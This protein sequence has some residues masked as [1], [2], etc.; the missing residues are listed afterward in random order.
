MKIKIRNKNKIEDTRINILG[1]I[2]FVLLFFIWFFYGEKTSESFG[3]FMWFW[4]LIWCWVILGYIIFLILT[5]SVRKLIYKIIKTHQFQ[6]VKSITMMNSYLRNSNFLNHHN[7]YQNT[8]LEKKYK[9]YKYSLFCK[10]IIKNATVIGLCVIL[11]FLF[12]NMLLQII[13]LPIV[14]TIAIVPLILKDKIV[15]L[16]RWEKPKRINKKK[17]ED[18]LYFRRIIPNSFQKSEHKI[19]FY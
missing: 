3:K 2:Y 14:L 15:S 17:K 8:D 4:I 13:M 1:S 9:I 6:E 16:I 18:I 12:P 10:F 7:Y 19:F 11:W 5:P